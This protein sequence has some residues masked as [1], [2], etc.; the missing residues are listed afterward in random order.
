MDLAALYRPKFQPVPYFVDGMLI[1]P[2]CAVAP[3][4]IYVGRLAGRRANDR[5]QFYPSFGTYVHQNLPGTKFAD[6]DVGDPVAVQKNVM[7][8]AHPI[9]EPSETFLA[10]VPVMQDA[11]RIMFGDAFSLEDCTLQQ[12][13]EFAP[14]EFQNCSHGAPGMVWDDS[15]TN[16]RDVVVDLGY[17]T[18]Y[19]LCVRGAF[20]IPF[21]DK[22]CNKTELRA[23]ENGQL[24]TARGFTPCQFHDFLLATLVLGPSLHRLENRSWI[25]VG[26]N[27]FALGYDKLYHELLAAQTELELPD[28]FCC[29]DIGGNDKQQRDFLRAVFTG[30][31]DVPSWLLGLFKHI[32]S[33]IDESYLVDQNGFVFYRKTGLSSGKKITLSWNSLVGCV[34]MLYLLILKGVNFYHMMKWPTAVFGDDNISAWPFEDSLDK[35]YNAQIT[36]FTGLTASNE[37]PILSGEL[38]QRDTIPLLECQFLSF[39]FRQVDGRIFPSTI[40]PNKCLERLNMMTPLENRR[41]LIKQFILMHFYSEHLNPI[42]TELYLREFPDERV[43]LSQIV[44]QAKSL[45]N[46]LEAVSPEYENHLIIF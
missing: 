35:F 38:T 22:S 29:I 18:L 13:E 36:P 45:H 42:L 9:L 44:S 30:C 20:V 1:A 25:K 46:E 33:Q 40:Q 43:E 7:K 3:T 37:N 19:Y 2:A 34:V 27:F 8:Y 10:A 26:M 17:A 11:L 21:F 12:F 28:K 41:L 32:C 23:I 14:S 31:Y 39:K 16:K 24:K 5:S 4:L 6:A 15:Y